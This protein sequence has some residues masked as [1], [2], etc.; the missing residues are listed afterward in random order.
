[1]TAAERRTRVNVALQAVDLQDRANHYPRQMSGGQE[2]RVGIARAIV[3]HPRVVVADEPTGDLD[4]L[5]EELISSGYEM[6]EGNNP[7]NLNITSVNSVADADQDPCNDKSGVVISAVMPAPNKP[8]NF[9]LTLS[10][11]CN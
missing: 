1:M 6:Q 7:V 2:Q 5:I 8:L 3:A 9:I 10:L 11:Y 4:P